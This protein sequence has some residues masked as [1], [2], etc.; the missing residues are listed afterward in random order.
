MKKARLLARVE[1]HF[2]SPLVG[3]GGFE[4]SE[5]PG[6]GYMNRATPHPPSMLRIL[7][8]LSHPAQQ[9]LRSGEREEDNK[10]PRP[11]PGLSI[12]CDETRDAYLSPRFFSAVP[13]MSPSVAPESD[14]P[15]CAMA[16]FSSATSSALIETCTLRAFLSNWI[17]RASTFS[18][19]AKRSA[20]WSLRSRAS[21]DRLMKVVKSVPAILT[22]MPLSLTSS[23]SQ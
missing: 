21:S 7:G 5:K 19:T 13:R 14:E 20:R 11:K 17:T 4:R 8:T 22:S 18:P 10:K 1:P 2:P 9:L 12:C 23:T 16:S 3:E 6:E 15:Y